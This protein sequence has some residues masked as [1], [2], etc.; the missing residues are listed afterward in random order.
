MARPTFSSK[1]ASRKNG[2]IA[3]SGKCRDVLTYLF[4]SASI[5]NIYVSSLSST[6]SKKGRVLGRVPRLTVVS[7]RVPGEMRVFD[8]SY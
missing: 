5:S 7:G 8:S 6:V 4:W 2:F 1:R 3:C